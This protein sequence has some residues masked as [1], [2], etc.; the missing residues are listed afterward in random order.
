MKLI[1]KFL[2]ATILAFTVSGFVVSHAAA[3]TLVYCSE[4]SPEGFDAALSLSGATYDASARNISDTL[5]KIKRGSTEFEPGLA[6]SWSISSDGKEYTFHLRKGVKFHMSDYFTPSRDFNADDVIFTF[7]RQGNK[8]NPYYGKGTWPQY[9]SYSFPSLI[10]RIERIDDHTVKFVLTRPQA[11]MIA[12][13]S[14]TFATIQSKEYADQLIATGHKDLLNLKPIGTGPYQFVD[15]QPD[16]V[17]RYRADPD[18]W[19]GKQKI[20]D[21][22]FVITP[23]AAVRYQKLKAG[24]CNV[25]AY[26]NPADLA[27]M[28]ADPSINLLRTEGL[29]VSYM[30]YNTMVAP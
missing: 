8:A 27:A 4:A 24:E 29:N 30:A 20:D 18:Y 9:N 11:T 17:I 5:V 23:D 28:R 22:V 26:P 7:D 19:G 12:S 15:Y 21:L 6:E 14:L 1:E 2:F 25:M 13:L 10:D 3:K 16:S